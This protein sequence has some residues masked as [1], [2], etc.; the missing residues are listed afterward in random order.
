[1]SK[2][3]NKLRNQTDQNKL[4]EETQREEPQPEK[5]KSAFTDKFKKQV[6][7][8]DYYKTNDT[9]AYKGM[10]DAQVNAAYKELQLRYAQN[11]PGGGSRKRGSSKKHRIRKN[12]RKNTRKNKRKPRKK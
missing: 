6:S 3:V 1:M 4:P 9:G 7:N 10:S 11:N 2:Y 5:N 12:K 8:Q